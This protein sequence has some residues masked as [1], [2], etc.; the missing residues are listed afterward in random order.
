MNIQ[1]KNFWKANLSEFNC[2]ALYGNFHIMGRLEKK[3]L[4]ELKPGARVASNHFRFPHWKPTKA[5]G[6]VYLYTKGQK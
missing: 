2:V 3:L 6:D 1:L 5:K 4:K